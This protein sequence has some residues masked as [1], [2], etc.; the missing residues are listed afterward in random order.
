MSVFLTQAFERWMAQCA[1]DNIPAR[2]DALI[3]ARMGGAPLRDAPF[4]PLKTLPYQAV[5][6]SIG[7]S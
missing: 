7:K 1:I 5:T 2:P 3:F 6:H 4:P